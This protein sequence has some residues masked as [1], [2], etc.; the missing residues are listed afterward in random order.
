MPDVS[1]N[2]I[3]FVIKGSSDEASDSI[4]KLAERLNELNASIAQAESVSK[5]STSIKSV[6]NAAKKA[7]SPLSGFLASIKR[8][9]MYRAIRAIIKSVTESIKEGAEQFYNFTKKAEPAFTNYAKA[10]DGVKTSSALMKA[11][12]GA[13]FGSLFTAIA[14]VI[15]SLIDLVTR[16][17]NVLTMVF[18]RLS[19]SSGWYKAT[20]GAAEAITGVGGA[21][22]EA[23]KYLAPFDELNRLPSNNGGG[24]GGSSSGSG[25]Q[26]EWVDFEQFDIGDGIASI[27]DWIKDAFNNMSAWIESVDWKNVVQNIVAKLVEWF[28][29]VDWNGLAQSISEFVGAAFGAAVGL[30]QSFVVEFVTLVGGLIYKMFVNDDGTAK[31]GEEIVKGIFKGITN[32]I[33]T[34]GTWLI[35]NVLKPFVDGFKKAFGIAS[36]AKEMEEPG[37]MVGEGILAGIKKPFE[38]IGTWLN[39]NIVQPVKDWLKNAGGI[40][41]ISVKLTLKAIFQNFTTAGLS[42]LLKNTWNAF[43]SRAANL[44]TSLKGTA[45]S[46]YN[47]LLTRWNAIKTKTANLY[48]YLKQGFATSTL[49]TLRSSWDALKTKSV[50]LTASLIASAVSS[51]ISKWNA[52]KSKTLSLTVSLSNTVK[53]A[54][55]TA[56]NAWNNSWLSGTLGRLPTLARGGIVD[57][58][59]FIGNAI[60]GEA[61]KEAIVPLERNTEW[62]GMVASGLM[63]KLSNTGSG[64][65]YSAMGDAMYRAM[66]RALAEN[67]DDRDIILDGAVVYNSVVQRNKNESFRIGRNPLLA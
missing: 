30:L 62:V 37:Q 6:G 4:D 66:S 1:L 45:T 43:K 50:S 54:W 19:G 46:T 57:Q 11:Q 22:K 49:N 12:L 14:P 33:S 35:D 3:E 65:D 42:S 21:A 59:T 51:F 39:D 16:F 29:K 34:V 61:G 44:T 31:T 18:A 36:P 26:Y 15:N 63:E 38:A 20:T 52:L 5:L 10:L 40:G 23:M 13:A 25:A 8:I 60:V 47:Y 32:I 2:G 28:K 9:A 17:A 48:S 64:F 53:S 41:D 27:F 67:Q 7:A 55:N 56:A 24:G 58:T